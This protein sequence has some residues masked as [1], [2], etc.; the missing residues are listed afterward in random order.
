MAEKMTNELMEKKLNIKKGDIYYYV[1]FSED[2]KSSMIQYEEWH[3]RSV[4]KGSAFATE[5]NSLTWVRNDPKK[6]SDQSMGWA[7]SIPS[8]CKERI[9]LSG[10]LGKLPTGWSKTKK[11]ALGKSLPKIKKTL[12]EYQKAV[13]R[14]KKIQTAIE[15]KRIILTTK[16]AGDE[17]I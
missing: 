1:W 13:T 4:Q 12:A 16:E 9:F 3:I 6:H 17:K 5:K 7:T 2:P 15:K 10:T 11:G 8:Y 14:L